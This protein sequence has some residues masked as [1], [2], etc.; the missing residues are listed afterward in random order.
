M[1][2][3]RPRELVLAVILTGTAGFLDAVG[4]LNLGGYF[5]SFMSGN[6]TRMSAEFVHGSWTSVGKAFGI[7][8]LF[9]AGA[10]L[11][12]VLARFGDGRVTVLAST[13]GVVGLSALAT[14]AHW[15]PVPPILIVAVAMGILNATFLSNGEVSVGLTYMTGTLV[16]ASQRLVDAFYGGPRWLWLRY[17]GL[18][19]ALALGAL[20]G[21]WAYTQIGLDVLWFVFAALGLITVVTWRIRTQ[22]AI[23]D[24]D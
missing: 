22:S 12:S 18:W 14:A 13:T 2:T 4:F 19:L 3:I 17:F 15:F 11:G 24:A 1:Q 16:K 21:A 5:V 20:L 9:I 10:V 7:I 23:S 6:T 8:G